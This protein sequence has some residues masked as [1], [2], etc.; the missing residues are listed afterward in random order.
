M[1]SGTSNNPMFNGV[2]NGF[3]TGSHTYFGGTNN[4]TN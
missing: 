2:I 4:N 1:N 3:G